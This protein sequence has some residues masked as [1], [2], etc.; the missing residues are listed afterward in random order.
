MTAKILDVYFHNRIIGKLAQDKYGELNFTYSENWLA[1]P[2]AI[3]ISCSL[4]L[5][6]AS[7]NKKECRAF[8][9]GIL[10][11]ENQRKIIAKNLSISANNALILLGKNRLFR[12]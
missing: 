9:G 8:F 6:K 12:L 3:K 5:Q 1:D 2:N 7:F 4:P 11:E 10:P